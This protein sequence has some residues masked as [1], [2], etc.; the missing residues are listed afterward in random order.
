[1]SINYYGEYVI[2]KSEIERYNS[3]ELY[4]LFKVIENA[5]V[6][7]NIGHKAMASYAESIAI[8]HGLWLPANSSDSDSNN[9][10][11]LQLSFESDVLATFGPL[12]SYLLSSTRE[13]LSRM[14]I[15]HDRIVNELQKRQD[16]F[17]NWLTTGVNEYA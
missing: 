13:R 12:S 8:K 3:Q 1:M 7:A 15:T 16:N 5:M 14:E 10:D 2:P 9:I 6:I 17:L 11:E 4:D